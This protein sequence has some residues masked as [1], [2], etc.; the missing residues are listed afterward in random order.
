MMISEAARKQIIELCKTSDDAIEAIAKRVGVSIHA[1]NTTILDHGKPK[2]IKRP[3]DPEFAVYCQ[4]CKQK[5][6]PTYL[7]KVGWVPC[8]EEY[9]QSSS[10]DF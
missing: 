7:N 3:S 6:K 1:V 9:L 4:H 10:I 8:L 5:V 2:T